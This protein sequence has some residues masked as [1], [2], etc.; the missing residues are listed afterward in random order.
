MVLVDTSIWVEHL[1]KGEASLMELLHRNLALTHPCVIGE[2]A[3][4]P[5]VNRAGVLAD[6]VALQ[7]ATPATNEETFHLI[8]ERRLW[9]RGIGWVE[10]QLL[11]SALLSNCHLW[12]STKG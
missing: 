9:R 3:C 5:I 6:L 2:L 4:G 8:Q 1:R 10:S 11:G 12:T 7:R